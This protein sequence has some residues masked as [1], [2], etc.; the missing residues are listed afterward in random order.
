[1]FT[2]NFNSLSDSLIEAS[3]KIITETE[4]MYT[5]VGPDG[6]KVQ[7]SENSI[8]HMNHQHLGKNDSIKS[9]QKHRITYNGKRTHE[10]VSEASKQKNASSDHD[11]YDHEDDYER[12][13]IDDHIR[14][15]DAEYD[16]AK[17]E[18]NKKMSEASNEEPNINHLELSEEELHEDDRRAI[19]AAIDAAKKA[20]KRPPSIESIKAKLAADKA[21]K[22]VYKALKS[23]SNSP[24][25]GLAPL[26]KPSRN[27]DDDDEGL[28][29]DPET[30]EKDLVPAKKHIMNQL[31]QAAQSMKAQHSVTFA[32]GKTHSVPKH[33][34]KD[35][36]NHYNSI[37]KPYERENLQSKIGQSHDALMK[38]HSTISESSF[39]PNLKGDKK[40]IIEKKP[41]KL[42]EVPTETVKDVKMFNQNE[43]KDDEP[44][45]EPDS[46]KV[47]W[48]ASKQ[49]RATWLAKKARDTMKKKVETK[50]EQVSPINSLDPNT[51]KQVMYKE[52]IEHIDERKMT[53]AEMKKREKIVMRLKDKMAGFKK[54]YGER[55]KDV[56]YATATK[57]AMKEETPSNKTMTGKKAN[58]VEINPSAPTKEGI[59][60][61]STT[62]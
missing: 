39:D 41:K 26:K 52:E 10:V 43:E 53:D 28:H 60:I 38:H 15:A 48:T 40:M 49:S 23:Q 5:L 61:K 25:S 11:D 20:G 56:M 17:R 13:E 62:T 9:G 8:R 22:D 30:G 57:Q 21:A 31:R 18:K 32:D 54:R 44:P 46:K 6:T 45:F 27:S 37:Q 59:G 35:L 36:V 14:D 19:R 50:E 3:K 29:T 12:D 1:M 51:K 4:K 42:D 55:A 7:R 16:K 47:N 58:P 2:K 34:A 24:K 33:V